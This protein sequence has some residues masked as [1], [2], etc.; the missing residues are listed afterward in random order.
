MTDIFSGSWQHYRAFDPGAGGYQRT[1]G[2]VV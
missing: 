2:L 1:A